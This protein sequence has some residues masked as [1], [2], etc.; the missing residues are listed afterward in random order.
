MFIWLI[1]CLCQG[2]YRESNADTANRA[3]NYD[4][5]GGSGDGYATYNNEGRGRGGGRGRRKNN[6]GGPSDRGGPRPPY[7]PEKFGIG[8]D[9]RRNPAHL[10]E[11]IGKVSRNDEHLGM[12]FFEIGLWHR[13]ATTRSWP[14]TRARLS[15]AGGAWERLAAKE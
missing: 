7:K 11:R 4:G 8:Y 3:N 15:A 10:K 14:E 13:C 5:P 2:M 1:V 6:R 12:N 9:T